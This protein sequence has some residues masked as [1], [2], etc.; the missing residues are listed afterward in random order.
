MFGLPTWVIWLVTGVVF[1]ILEI[2][3]ATFFMLWFGV[4]A[5]CI[6]ILILLFPKA[7]ESGINQAFL[8]LILSVLISIFW[9]KVLQP[10]RTMTTKQKGLKNGDLINEQGVVVRVPTT[11]KAGIIRFHVP[12]CGDTEW[13]FRPENTDET[14]KIGDRVKVINIV[15]NELVVRLHN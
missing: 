3:T 8:W 6:P 12:I 7:L 11:T 2:F 15:D 9:F 4:S 13:R 10:M 1:I 14:M 5:F